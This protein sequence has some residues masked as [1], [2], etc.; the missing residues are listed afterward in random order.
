MKKYLV[1]LIVFFTAFIISCKDSIL[2]DEDLAF[3][4]IMETN[5]KGELIGEVDNEDWLEQWN[6]PE[7]DSNG[8]MIPLTY[9]V[10]PAYPNPTKRFT[11]LRYSVPFD[12]SVH[13]ELDDRVMNKKTVL[14]S[15]KMKAGYY[16]LYVDLK[17]GNPELVR[18]DGLVR[19]YFRVPTKEK[20]PLVYGDLKVIS[21]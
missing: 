8:N 17:Y 6:Y 3:K 13:I 16:S 14:L 1:L 7:K 4:G 18:K 5:E 11:T 20:F 12:D 2:T 9:S 21:E 19:L 15:K 10:K